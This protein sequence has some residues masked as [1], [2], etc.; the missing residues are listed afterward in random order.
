MPRITFGPLVADLLAPDELTAA[1]RE[2]IARREPAQLVTLNALMARKAHRDPAYAAA[3]QQAGLV[4]PESAGIAW[5]IRFLTSQPVPRRTAGIDIMTRL[6]AQAAAEGWRVFFFGAQ[7]GVAAAAAENLRLRFPGLPIAGT[8]DGYQEAADQK[9]LCGRIRAANP[10]LLFVALA[11]PA[12]D[13]WIQHNLHTLGVPLV[14]GVGGSF[15]VIAGNL[16]RAPAWMQHAGLEWLYRTLQQ[17]WRL[18][19][20]LQLPLFVAMII[21]WKLNRQH[22]RNT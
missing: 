16:R 7:Q 9:A 13:L 10:D 11:L 15:D 5:A 4:I 22:H 20:I 8:A 6:C 17:P 1:V 3:I 12:Q 19:R 14:M 21:R 2:R 18:Q